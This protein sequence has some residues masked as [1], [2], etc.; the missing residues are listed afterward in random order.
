MEPFEEPVP[1]PIG[2]EL[3]L[4]TFAPREIGDLIPD[5]LEACREKGI[6]EVRLIHGKGSGQLRRGVHALLP[7]LDMV[8]RFAQASE[9]T[10]GLGATWVWLTPLASNSSTA[11]HESKH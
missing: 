8:Q 6:L 2:P 9:T 1:L 3:D 5:Y 11:P 4:H 7:R 10:G